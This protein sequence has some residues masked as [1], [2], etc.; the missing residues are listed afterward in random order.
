[1]GFATNIATRW[2]T[3]CALAITLI[4]LGGAS[5]CG[6]DRDRGTGTDET[7]GNTPAEATGAASTAPL[8]ENAT[9]EQA[10]A[11]PDP[12]QRVQRVARILEHATPDQL[13]TIKPAIESAP[14]NWGDLEYALFAGWWARFDP[15]SA[16]AYCDEELRLRH[17]R[18]IA[19]VLRAWGHKNPQEALASGW[20]AAVTDTSGLNPDYID[21]L[22]VGWFESGQPG[23]DAWL[24]GLDPTTKAA[25]LIAYMRMRILRDGRRPALEWSLDAPFTPDLQRLLLATGLNI[26]ARQ[27]PPMAIEF[28]DQAAKKGIDVRTFIARIGRGWANTNPREAMEWVVSQEVEYEGERWRAVGDIARI[29]LNKDEQ[30]AV[31]WLATKSE[32]WADLVRK[33]AI[34]HHMTRN[35]YRVDWLDMMKRAS[36]FVNPE[37]R[38]LQYL[39]NVQRWKVIDPEAASRWIEENKALLGDKIEFVD[40]L[41]SGE[42]Q[43]IQQSLKETAPAENS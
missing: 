15:A 11:H 38:Q 25:A 12:L 36:Q 7:P 40:Q 26:V 41:P 9:L 34:Q 16:M 18:V 39:V 37:Q 10:L 43:A 42:F 3:Q 8:P 29:W 22:V 24:A 31:E 28:M 33:Q 20:L 23:L 27:E 35:R 32:P 30:G 2:G 19:E 6:S 4:S 5:G 1:M 21:A 14:L 17:P 13:D